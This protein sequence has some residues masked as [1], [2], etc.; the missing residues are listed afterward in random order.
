MAL[1]LRPLPT[2]AS[3]LISF[4][5]YP[6]LSVLVCSAFVRFEYGDHH[7]CGNFLHKRVFQDLSKFGA[8]ERSMV[9]SLCVP[10]DLGE[11]E[12]E[13]RVKKKKN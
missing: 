2:V 4:T 12:Q 10:V 3:F 1:R 9:L 8:A 7:D 5:R 6:Y 11:L 13:G